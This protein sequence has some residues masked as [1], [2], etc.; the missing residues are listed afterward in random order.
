MAIKYYCEE[1]SL[2]LITSRVIWK[3]FTIINI[4]LIFPKQILKKDE[5]FFA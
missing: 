4:S 5:L 3:Y 2:V 1:N